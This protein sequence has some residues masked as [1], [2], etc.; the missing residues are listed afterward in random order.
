MP[1]P[2][3]PP[4]KPAL[5]HLIVNADDYPALIVALPDIRP[6]EACSKPAALGV[7]PLDAEDSYSTYV[8]PWCGE[9]IDASRADISRMD[10]WYMPESES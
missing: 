6:C 2:P 3:V 5:G 4:A 10:T 8:M 9:C 7:K 1:V